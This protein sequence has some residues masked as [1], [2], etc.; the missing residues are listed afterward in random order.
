V[1]RSW[2]TCAEREQAMRV[3]SVSLTILLAAC[4]LAVSIYLAKTS[5]TGT[6]EPVAVIAGQTIYE[7]ELLPRVQAQLR[8]QEYELKSGALENLVDQK[9]LE[10]EA[11]KKGIAVGQ[12][13]EQEVDA[14]V[15]EP[16]EAEL[17]AAYQSQKDNPNPPFEEVK[18]QVQQAL[19]QAKLQEARQEFLKH[20]REQAGV[21]ILLRPPKV[22]VGYDPARLRGNAWAPVIIVEFADFQCPFC[23]QA[24]PTLRDLLTKY[25][26][27]VSLAYRDFP[28]RGI[29]AQGQL[30]AEASRC[31]GEQGRFWEYHDLLFANP[32]K[33]KRDG[34]VEH[35]RSLKLDEKQFDSCLSSGK[36]EA[37]IEEDLQ[38]GI[39]AGV[40]GTPGF[41]INGS[42]LSGIQP[43]AVFEEMIQAEMGVP[44]EKPAAQ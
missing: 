14:K 12:V 30:A 11:K 41:F 44:K 25:K 5:I 21:S 28:L 10:A 16:T 36:Y 26:G 24:Q 1:G 9:L 39:R 6:K 22:E 33:L 23:R 38:E 18:A 8:N 2:L 27:R 42:F 40:A 43:E 19:K 29:H 37:R 3:S 35:A 17:K 7:D 20:L 13:L 31:A 15:A 34:L 4:L 32:D